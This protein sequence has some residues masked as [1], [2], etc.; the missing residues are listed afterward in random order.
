MNLTLNLP[1]PIANIQSPWQQAI[2]RLI[3]PLNLIYSHEKNENLV[4]HLYLHR[5][6]TLEYLAKLEWDNKIKPSTPHGY[7][8]IYKPLAELWRRVVI[9]CDRLHSHYPQDYANAADWFVDVYVELALEGITQNKGKAH[10]IAI[11]QSQN[12]SIK[13]FENPFKEELTPHTY[14]FVNYL[15]ERSESSNNFKKEVMLPLLEARQKL[16]KELRS[17]KIISIR[18][19]DNGIFFASGT[20]AKKRTNLEPKI[21]SV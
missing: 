15:I 11:M 17:S 3:H 2:I 9:A 20:N 21:W 18:E 13:S 1:F 8:H 10:D 19:D 14:A 16:V 5:F 4:G 12:K 7:T 6:Y